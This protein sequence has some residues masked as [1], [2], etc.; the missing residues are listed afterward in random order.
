MAL[1]DELGSDVDSAAEPL[2]EFERAVVLDADAF[3]AY[4]EAEVA[5]EDSYLEMAGDCVRSLDYRAAGALVEVVRGLNRSLCEIA[6]RELGRRCGGDDDDEAYC[7]SL[8]RWRDLA[9]GLVHLLEGQQAFWDAQYS[10]LRFAD[11]DE[12]RESYARACEAFEM[13][14]QHD[15]PQ[16][17]IARTLAARCR[18]MHDF[19]LGLSQ[20]HEA[21]Y[22]GAV[23][24]FDEAR[25]KMQRLLRSVSGAAGGEDKQSHV[26]DL[27]HQVEG[28]LVMADAC[29]WMARFLQAATASDFDE[30]IEH[31]AHMVASSEQS[32]DAAVRLNLHE[33]V[34]GLRRA[35]LA[36][37]R[38]WLEWA[39]GEHAADQEDWQ[40]SADHAIAALNH[41]HD[42]A[43]IGAGSEFAAVRAIRSQFGSFTMLIRSTRRRAEREE[44]LRS[45]IGLLLDQGGIRIDNRIDNKGEVDMSNT[46]NIGNISFDGQGHVVALGDQT[47]STVDNRKARASSAD[48]GELT[49]LA[50]ELGRLRQVLEA[51]ASGPD[52]HAAAEAVGAA[53][54]AA[55]QHDEPTMREYLAKA[56]QWALDAATR[57]GLPIAQAAIM[58]GLGLA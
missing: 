18:Y 12:A 23:Y 17:D 56:G 11:H 2:A 54:D 34:V 7:A 16:A 25:E 30:A 24:R 57:L 43:R 35:Q 52:E 10:L 40:G 22:N 28:D 37:R 36:L 4:V 21:E 13:V 3:E 48:A 14:V 6:E 42:A 47:V 15:L 58:R 19:V 5:L 9:L 29:Q 55:A 49:K 44:Q 41:W 8:R 50:A 39:R 38:G 32:L 1:L 20:L 51:D 45:Q 53:A 26:D 46:N 31:G 33:R 27:R